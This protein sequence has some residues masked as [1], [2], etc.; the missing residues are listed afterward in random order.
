M[1]NYAP[2]R[3]IEINIVWGGPIWDIIE[4][5]CVIKLQKNHSP[6]MCE[7][8]TLNGYLGGDSYDN[9]KLFR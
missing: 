9:F 5:Y 6:C 3:I 4:F 1:Y 8:E 2:E 7:T